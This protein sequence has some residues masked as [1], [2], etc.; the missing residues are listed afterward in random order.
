MIRLFHRLTPLQK[1]L[2]GYLTL[3]ALGWILL[4]LPV[5]HSGGSAVIDHLFTATSALTTTGLTT[6]NVADSYS[7]AGEIVILLLLQIGG[8]GYMSLAGWLLLESHY[9]LK[10][11]EDEE[12]EEMVESDYTVPRGSDHRS[13]LIKLLGFTLACEAIGAV[14]LSVAFS[15]HGEELPVWKGIFI[16]V[17]AFCTAGLHLFDSSLHGFTDNVSVNLTVSA[18]SLA[19]SFGFL[20]FVDVYDRLLGHTKRLGVSTRAIF[21]VMAVSLVGVTATLMF[22]DPYFNTGGEVDLGLMAG[23]FQAISTVSTTGFSTVPIDRL[24]MASTFLL[25][26]FMFIG[27]SPSGTGGGIKNTTAATAFAYLVAVVRRKKDIVLL[28]A[29]LSQKRVHLAMALLVV[30]LI[31]V[32]VAGF[33]LLVGTP[34]ATFAPIFEVVSALGTVGLSLGATGEVDAG[35]KVLLIAL[36][37]LG[38]LGTLSVIM[39][40]LGH[41]PNSAE[42]A[43]SGDGDDGD[44]AIEG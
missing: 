3:L 31:L 17:S 4:N 16:A 32:L 12:K 42:H 38:R 33:A 14:I 6:I 35:G 41:S 28:G 37:I 36:M 19:G 25:T 13:F 10:S 24:S 29:R 1:L 8:I 30:N 15:A 23:A 9:G 21:L 7:F 2:C 22:Y 26:I 11:R 44:I 40:V 34:D 20:F 18:L 43:D 27:A 39:A 5:F